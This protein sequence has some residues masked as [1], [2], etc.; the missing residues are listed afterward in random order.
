MPD[1]IVISV[2]CWIHGSHLLN[3]EQK[4]LYTVAMVL[5]ILWLKQSVC[6]AYS[7]WLTT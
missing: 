6:D 3:E 4:M 1:V 5:L 2:N 7:G